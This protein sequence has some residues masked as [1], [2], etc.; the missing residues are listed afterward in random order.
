M[1]EGFFV[2]NIKMKKIIILTFLSNFLIAQKDS[3]LVVKL[4]E[5]EIKSIKSSSI[6]ESIPLSITKIKVPK[7]WSKQQLS[8]QEYVSSVPGLLA[9]NA[10]N[11]AQDLRI[12]IRGFGQDQLS[13]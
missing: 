9:F 8:L 4:D 2:F 6:F 12:S 7:L 10:N 1:T 13:V 5:I 11:F 3:L